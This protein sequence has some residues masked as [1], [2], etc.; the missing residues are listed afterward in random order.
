MIRG[1]RGKFQHVVEYTAEAIL[2]EP[3]LIAFHS[4]RRHKTFLGTYPNLA[5]PKT[6]NEKLLHRMVFDRRPILLELEDKYA[7]RNFVR[8]RIGEDILPAL[9]WVTTDPRDIPFDDLPDRFVAKATHGC[10][11]NYLVPDKSSLNRHDLV[12]RCTSWLSRNFYETSHEWVYKHIEPRLIIEEFVSDDTG[13]SPRTYKVFVFNGRASLI[14]VLTKAFEAGATRRPARDLRIDYYTTSW[15]RLNVKTRLKLIEQPVPHP[16]H[17]AEIIASA[18]ILGDGLDFIRVD[19]Y[20]S[21]KVYFGEM[22][23]YPGGGL[24]FSDPKWNRH[25]G[26]LWDSSVRGPVR[27]PGRAEVDVRRRRGGLLARL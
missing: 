17:L 26:E 16:P 7:A 5:R 10:G 20:D 11:W 23:V 14:V 12:D 6:F 25:F 9:Y 3:A 27:K 1:L 22:A 4:L 24:E 21:R 13:L 8:K 18:E 19:F 2:P 15:D